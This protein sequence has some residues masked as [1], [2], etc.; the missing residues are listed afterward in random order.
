MEQNFVAEL[1]VPILFFLHR[2]VVD[3][4]LLYL[5]HLLRPQVKLLLESCEVGE[6]V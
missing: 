3:S 5:L 2:L 4:L 6:P 1:V